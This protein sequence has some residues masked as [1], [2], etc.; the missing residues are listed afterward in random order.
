MKDYYEVFFGLVEAMSLFKKSKFLYELYNFF[1]YPKL[2]RNMSLYKELGLKKKY[3]S[4]I[5]DRDFKDLILHCLN[6]IS[7]KFIR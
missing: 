3:Y 1:Q 6:L 4:S 2:K 5:S 7:K